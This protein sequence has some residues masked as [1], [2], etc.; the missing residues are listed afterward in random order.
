MKKRIVWIVIVLVIVSIIGYKIKSGGQAVE[1]ESAKV[2]KG[3]IEEYIEETGIIMLEEETAVYSSVTGKVAE[4][5]KKVGETVKAGDILAV[6]DDEDILLQIKAM[7]AQ[8]LSVSAK[9][10]EAKSSTDEVELRKLSAQV[11]SAEALY[12][13][14]KK[15]ADSS[16][17]LYEAGA[18]SLDAYQSAIVELAETEAGLESAKSSLAQAEKGLSV[19]VRKQYEAQLSEMQAKIEQLKLKSADAVIKSPI[20]GMVM[21]SE[22]KEGNIV[23][24]GSKLFEIGGPKGFFIESDVL[25]ED[26]PGIKVGSLVM[27]D[28]EDLGIKAM[29]GIVRKIHPRAF[30]KMS[31]LGIEQKRVKVEIDLD[32]AFEGLKSGYDLTVKIITQSAKDTLLI[33]EKAIFDYQGKEHVFVNED[34]AAVLRAIEKGLESDELVEVLKGLSEGE[35][36]IISPDENLEE[37]VKI[38]VKET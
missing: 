6:L 7:E 26:I 32:S 31:D 21:A 22:I 38:R 30:S 5:A 15:K 18:L 29:K 28:D 23:Q 19:N 16:R 27:I 33:P 8:K 12:E 4:I 36:V 3:N 11:R 2:T 25:I 17:V 13:E 10:E 35:E 34:G 9:Y 24:M 20:D 14:L 37:G 1:V